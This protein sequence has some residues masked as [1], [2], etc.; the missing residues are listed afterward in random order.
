MSHEHYLQH[1]YTV[2]LQRCIPAHL[3]SSPPA[4]LALSLINPCSFPGRPDAVAVVM[5]LETR[6]LRSAESAFHLFGNKRSIS[7]GDSAACVRKCT[8][9][10]IRL[11][12]GKK[13]LQNKTTETKPLEPL[14]G[15]NK[16]WLVA[17]FIQ[18]HPVD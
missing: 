17:R 5:T 14:T 9:S 3:G 13:P 1:R 8:C 4:L 18:K 7:H 2:T 11:H 15:E 10:Y 12:A 6:W 16:V